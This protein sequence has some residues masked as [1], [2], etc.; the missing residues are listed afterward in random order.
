[1]ATVAPRRPGSVR[2]PGCDAPVS[3]GTH[4]HSSRVHTPGRGPERRSPRPEGHPQPDTL[5]SALATCLPVCVRD[6]PARA[7]TVPGCVQPGSLCTI[8]NITQWVLYGKLASG[9]C[10]WRSGRCGNRS[11]RHGALGG[12]RMALRMIVPAATI[13]PV[14]HQKDRGQDQQE[15][16]NQVGGDA[17]RG[18]CLLLPCCTGQIGDAAVCSAASNRYATLTAD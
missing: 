18:S 16:G 6:R 13:R 9:F 8:S 3:D 14:E 15:A 17:H 4:G 10:R 2:R 1:V 12:L 5:P 11:G 7:A